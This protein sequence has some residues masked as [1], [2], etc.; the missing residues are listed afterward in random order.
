MQYAIASVNFYFNYTTSKYFISN[1]TYIYF[2]LPIRNAAQVGIRNEL[3]VM[4]TSDPRTAFE[5]Y[6]T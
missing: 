5:I 1:T 3:H 6:G 4:D 2:W